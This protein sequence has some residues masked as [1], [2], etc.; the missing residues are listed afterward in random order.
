MAGLAVHEAL[1]AGSNRAEQFAAYGDW[2][3]QGIE[4]MRALV[5]SFYD[6]EFSMGAMVRA[7][8]DTRAEVTDCLIGNFF[9]RF[10]T[11]MNALGSF[12][13]LPEHLDHG[14]PKLPA[15]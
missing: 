13:A 14:G 5:H 3:C 12:A 6:P 8:P 7:Q 10:D 11:L 15:P 9:R 1:E 2:L 4:S